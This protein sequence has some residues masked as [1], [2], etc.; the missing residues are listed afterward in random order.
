MSAFTNI[1]VKKAVRESSGSASQVN[2]IENRVTGRIR[3]QS[4]GKD[5][6]RSHENRKREAVTLHSHVTALDPVAC[7]KVYGRK[8]EPFQF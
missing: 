6:L 2:H 4:A 7:M 1:T 8:Q 3:V 5:R